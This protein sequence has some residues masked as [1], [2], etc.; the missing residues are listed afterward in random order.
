MKKLGILILTVCSLL[1][2]G[3]DWL[4]LKPVDIYGI[5]NYWKSKSNVER[6]IVGLHGRIRSRQMA[7]LQMGELRG[8]YLRDEPQST[9]GQDKRDLPIVG[10]RL[11]VQEPGLS[12][13]GNFYMDIMQ[14]NYAIQQIETNPTID[15]LTTEER[16]YYLGMLYGMRSFYYFNL[17]RTWGGVPLVET[18]DVLGNFNSM[19]SLNKARAT[20]RETYAF[21]SKDI[22]KSLEYFKGDNFTQL[23]AYKASFWTKQASY[24]L[25]AELLLWGAKVKPIGEGTVY[26]ADPT[27]DFNKVVTL[28]G[29]IKTKTSLES[30]LST[31]FYTKDNKE[32]IFSIRYALSEASNSFRYFLYPE[33]TFG[34][35]WYKEGGKI[36]LGPDPLKVNSGA[37]QYEYKVGTTTNNDEFGL[38]RKFDSKDSRRDFTFMYFCKIEWIPGRPP[39]PGKTTE[40]LSM[41]KYLGN[42]FNGATRQY[43]DDYPIYRKADLLLMLAEAY[44]ELSDA[45]NTKACIDE[46]RKRAYGTNWSTAYGFTYVDKTQAEREILLERD[47]EFVAEGKRWYDVRRMLG[48][49]IA[50]ELNSGVQGKQLWPIAPSD[51]AKDPLLK[52]NDAYL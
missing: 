35:D 21:I 15:F 3:C 14:I 47:K 50:T 27:A 4:D 32:I 13:F 31:L 20:E 28:L 51:L 11:S 48:G 10:N 34:G 37:L 42:S 18:P 8:G 44:N 43:V 45:A 52:Q 2:T 17:F 40:G 49:T 22:D 33:A 41:K 12:N 16:N 29:E 46:V 6:F 36:P 23:P 9:V 39:K 25:K 30:D 19:S 1:M 38:Y 7:L 5:N 24:M 26:S